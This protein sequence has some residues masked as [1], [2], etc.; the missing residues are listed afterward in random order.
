[1]TKL[2]AIKAKKLIKVPRT[3]NFTQTHR[4]GSHF[5]FTHP[6]GRTT[7]VPVHPGKDLGKG[8]LHSIL[9]DI[10]LSPEKFQELLKK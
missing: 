4:K 3:L 10:K 6:D 1:M 8:L 7:V 9:Q 5:F 2:P